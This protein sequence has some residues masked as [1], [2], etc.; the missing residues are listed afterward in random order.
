MKLYT[1]MSVCAPGDALI[2]YDG[3]AT[4]GLTCEQQ[5]EHDAAAA[6]ALV[7]AMAQWRE[8]STQEAAKYWASEWIEGRATALLR[9]WG[10]EQEGE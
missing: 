9:Q 8:L 3:D 4:H 6:H 10:F 2:V 1:E 7:Q 5:L